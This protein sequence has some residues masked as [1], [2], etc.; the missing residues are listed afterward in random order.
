MPI[1]HKTL[2]DT[3]SLALQLNRSQR[4][5]GDAYLKFAINSQMTAVFSMQHVQEVLMLSAQRLTP[6]P[7]MPA[8]ILGLMNRRS[9]VL[10]VVNLAQLLGLPWGASVQQYSLVMIQVGTV[11]VGLAVQQVDGITWFQPDAI[12]S[13]IGQVAPSLVPY[14]RGYVLQSRDQQQEAVLVLDAEAITQSSILCSP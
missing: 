9:R 12:Q 10:W 3:S 1:H 7:N 2:M 6:M 11:P 14:L 13:P 5:P 4:T 8:C